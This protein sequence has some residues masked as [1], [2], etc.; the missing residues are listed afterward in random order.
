M[1]VFMKETFRIMKHMDKEHI[2]ILSKIMSI[3]EDGKKISLMV[4]DVKNSEMGHIMK[5]NF[6]ME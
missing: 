2:T 3:Q 6:V 4:K 5:G 1:V